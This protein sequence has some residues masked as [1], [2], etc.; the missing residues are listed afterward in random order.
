[1][2]VEVRAEGIG[3]GG[4]DEVL[5]DGFEALATGAGGQ[6]HIVEVLAL[7]VIAGGFERQVFLEDGA[8]LAQGLRIGER[9]RIVHRGLVWLGIVCWRKQSTKAGQAFCFS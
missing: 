2:L 9:W 7:A 5:A 8:G 4:L 6:E 1:M 3:L